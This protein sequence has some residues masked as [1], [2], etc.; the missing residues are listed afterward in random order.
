MAAFIHMAD[1][2]KGQAFM[3]RLDSLAAKEAPP[4]A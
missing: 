2:A 4:A 1:P 3:K